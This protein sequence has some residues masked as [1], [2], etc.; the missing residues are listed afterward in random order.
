MIKDGAK[1]LILSVG[2]VAH[3]NLI[4]GNWGPDHEKMGKGITLSNEEFAALQQAL[5]KME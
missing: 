2:M 1:S 4:Y 5:K 3:R